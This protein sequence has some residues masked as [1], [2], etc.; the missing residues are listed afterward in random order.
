MSS[1][2]L[3]RRYKKIISDKKKAEIL[4]WI[5]LVS[6]MGALVT[7]NLV[8]N[9]YKHPD[10][11]FWIDV[12]IFVIF[13]I[14][15]GISFRK[16]NDYVIDK[17]RE[18]F[19]VFYD[20]YK[21]LEEYKEDEKLRQKAQ[22]KMKQLSL[23]VGQWVKWSVP[24]VF[25]NELV[26]SMY[27]NLWKVV[28]FVDQ[29]KIDEISLFIEKLQH[30]SEIILIRDPSIEEWK[31]FNNSMTS[32]EILP[33]KDLS[34]RASIFS[35]MPVLKYVLIGPLAGIIINPIL[36][37]EGMKSADAL[38]GGVIVA[39]TAMGAIAALAALVQRSTKG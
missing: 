30:I 26:D 1:T 25:R 38:L 32:L 3:D 28:K 14:V 19:F 34:Q 15:L 4:R 23:H 31:D 20:A 10:N 29:G 7:V 17:K 5:L 35:K 22:N 16:Q 27:G 12:V 24:Q 9:N 21:T 33:D 8:L 6:I 39:F 13:S 18:Q 2:N 37:Y 11:N 36:T